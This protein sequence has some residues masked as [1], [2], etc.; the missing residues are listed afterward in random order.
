MKVYRYKTKISNKGE[1]M[2][3]L[4]PALYN[5][6]VDVIILQKENKRRENFKAKDFVDK[7]AGFLK[8][9]DTDKIN[10]LS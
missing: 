9:N 10:Y 4:N 6:E 1:L 2:I 8:N 7:W 3:S 5:K